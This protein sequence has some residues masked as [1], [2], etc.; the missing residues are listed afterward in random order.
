M[1]NYPHGVWIWQLAKIRTDYLD[2]LVAR[3]VKRIYIK[4]F[5]GKFQGQLKPTFWDWQCSKEIVQKFKSR[6]IEFYG[7]GF[8]Y[9]TPDVD[10][11]VAKVKLALAAGIDGYILDV[12]KDVEDTRTHPNVEKLLLSLRP[13]V[14]SGTLGY[15]SFGHPG[16]HPNVPWKMLDRYCDL[17]LPQIYFE[18]FTFKPTTPEE[19]KDCLDAHK[20]LG[21]KKPI[22]PIWSSETDAPNP[23]SAAE[24]QEYLNNAPGSSIWRIPHLGERGEAWN[25]IYSGFELPTLNRVLRRGSKGEDV[26]ALQRVLNARGF[27]AGKVDG[28]FGPK[29]ETAVKAFQT[30]AKIG[31]DGK[32]GAQTWT[33][34][35][36]K[37]KPRAIASGVQS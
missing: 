2:R 28:D 33:A 27:N 1:V 9:G 13:L 8:H 18:K 12:E 20:K 25:L 36:G 14:K 21:L 35:G 16:L 3:R 34:L 7:Y 5:D 15:T 37:F 17:A 19:V 4:V 26:K 29:T 6:G 32:V 22:L 11:Q 31:V 24:L 10:E 23:A 30:E